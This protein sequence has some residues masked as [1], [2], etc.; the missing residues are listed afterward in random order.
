MIG[1][2]AAPTAAP[3]ASENH[4]PVGLFRKI[5]YISLNVLIVVHLVAIL[6]APLTVGPSSQIS[7]RVWGC[8]AP[9]LQALYLNHGFHYFAPEPGSS[10]LV[11]WSVT[12]EDGRVVSG[13]F[14]NFDIFPRLMYHRHFMLSEVLGNSSPELQPDIVRGFARNLLREHGGKTVSLSAIRHEL[15]SMARVRAGGKLTDPDLYTEQPFGTF[16]RE[17]LQ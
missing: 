16:T 9:Y 1:P 11:S 12:C 8:L 7:R 4:Q 14:P 13:R 15:S 2:I 17:D 3:G 6:S 10:N 5:G